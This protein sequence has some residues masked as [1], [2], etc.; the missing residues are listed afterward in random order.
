MPQANEMRYGKSCYH[1]DPHRVSACG[2][3]PALPP[4]DGAMCEALIGT[5]GQEFLREISEHEWDDGMSNIENGRLNQADALANAQQAYEFKKD[6]LRSV[7]SYGPGGDLL[8][9]AVADA[10]AGPAPDANEFKF[11]ADGTVSDIGLSAT[12]QSVQHQITQAQYTVA[13]Q[14]IQ[15]SNPYI[16]PAFF[17]GDGSLKSPGQISSDDWSK[18]DAQMTT[19]M[20]QYTQINTMLGKFSDTFGH[21]GGLK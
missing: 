12:E 9:N 13:S 15:D 16:D 19:A 5:S 4:N 21:I 11:N 17:N 8:T 10:I 18:Y 14:F 1:R 3:P 7:T 20:A 6:I 2:Y